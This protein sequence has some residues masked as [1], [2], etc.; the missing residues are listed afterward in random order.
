MLVI[1]DKGHRRGIV[2]SYEGRTF[3]GKESNRGQATQR[4]Q[5]KCVRQIRAKAFQINGVCDFNGS[6]YNASS[7]K[8]HKDVARCFVNSSRTRDACDCVRLR[9]VR[10]HYTPCVVCEYARLV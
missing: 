2:L 6:P 4:W 10:F 3:E 9:N 5:D 1:Y 7:S 8:G